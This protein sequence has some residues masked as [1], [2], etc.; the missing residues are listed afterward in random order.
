LNWDQGQKEVK[1]V[2]PFASKIVVENSPLGVEA[3][4]RAGIPYIVVMNNTPLEISS[5]FGDVG[6]E[7]NRIFKDTKSAG[8]LLKDWCCK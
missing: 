3:A 4:R 8:S 1:H 5:D 6:I 2:F 7:N